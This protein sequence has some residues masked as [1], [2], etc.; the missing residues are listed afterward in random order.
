MKKITTKDIVLVGVFAAMIFAL[1]KFGGFSI[2]TPTGATML[3]TANI[4]CILSGVLLG[5]THGGLAAG[6]GS[7]IFDLTDPRFIS[8]A[9]FTF[10]F[11]FIMA[12]LAGLVYEKLNNIALA[13]FI[14]AFSYV[15]LYFSKS[16]ISTVLEGSLFVPAL[17][18]NSS[19]L[20]TSGINAVVATIFAV[21][22]YPALKKAFMQ[23]KTAK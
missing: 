19:K 8:S 9:P 11:F 4:L 1:T 20:V 12:F 21:V 6:F 17:I 18:A 14:G 2:P 23:V 10:A 13:S 16:V 7:M 5:K 3:K 22:I 15:I